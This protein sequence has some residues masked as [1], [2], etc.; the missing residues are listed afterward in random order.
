MLSR[1]F[2]R[3]KLGF[4]AGCKT[5][6]RVPTD[7][8]R[9]RCVMSGR[10]RRERELERWRSTPRAELIPKWDQRGR[11]T[12]SEQILSV[13]ATTLRDWKV[14]PPGLRT[15]K[16]ATHYST[17]YSTRSQMA[18]S[19][20]SI[21]WIRDRGGMTHFPSR[22]LS[23]VSSSTVTDRATGKAVRVAGSYGQAI[24]RRDEHRQSDAS[25]VRGRFFG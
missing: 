6:Q 15:S 9:G 2:W 1:D 14:M 22:P 18:P 17:H 23:R 8:S 20:S 10:R 19:R 4:V 21:S 25:P 5:L 7:S 11:P 13:F 3:R 12:F 16:V 24:P